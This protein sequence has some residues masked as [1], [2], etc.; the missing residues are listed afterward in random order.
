MMHICSSKAIFHRD[1]PSPAISQ[2]VNDARTSF[3]GD[4]PSF[5]VLI[6]A[7]WFGC[8]FV[9]VGEWQK[10]CDENVSTLTVNYFK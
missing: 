6:V 9:R 2:A 4:A 3:A 7:K 1:L 10:F 8:E 5:E